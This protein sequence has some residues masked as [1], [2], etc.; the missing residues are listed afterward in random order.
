[1]IVL[2][3]EECFDIVIR[4]KESWAVHRFDS[5]LMEKMWRII[6]EWD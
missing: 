2:D 1:M 5:E 6:Y 3:S 4:A